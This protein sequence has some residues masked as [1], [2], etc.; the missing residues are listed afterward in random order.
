MFPGLVSL[1][2]IAYSLWPPLVEA[3]ARYLGI[4]LTGLPLTIF[5]LFL[6]SWLSLSM[7]VS[8]MAIK[9]EQ[10]QYFRWLGPVFLYL[11]GYGAFLCAVTFGA[12]IK[13]MQ[14][15]EMKWDKTVKTGKVN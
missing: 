13:E 1:S 7:A 6:Y 8:F 14:G 5:T 9:F 10:S 15:A 3:P 4:E 2:V 12:Y 11:G